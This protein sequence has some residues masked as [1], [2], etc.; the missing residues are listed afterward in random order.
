LIGQG[1]QFNLKHAFAAPGAVG[2]DFK[3]QP[4]PVEQLDL[5]FAFQI[6]LLDGTDG[7]ID[8]H[9][10]NIFGCKARLKFRDLAGAEQQPRL[11]LRQAHNLGPGYL[12]VGQGCGQR[13]R[14]GQPQRR[15]AT[16]AV[17]FQVGVQDESP[18]RLCPNVD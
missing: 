13:H 15:I 11:G 14:F 3:D 6:A 4:G 18:G 17:R 10:F 12:D 5:P 8:Q 7:A 1:G 9:E 2:E 16:A